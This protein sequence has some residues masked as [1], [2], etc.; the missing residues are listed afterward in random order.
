MGQ[1]G[2]SQDREALFSEFSTLFLLLAEERIQPKD[3]L[4][5]LRAAAASRRFAS[6]SL[7]GILKSE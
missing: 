3:D 2:S 4:V 7:R 5:E 6:L 1:D